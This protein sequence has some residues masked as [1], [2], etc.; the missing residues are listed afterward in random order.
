M[1]RVGEESVSHSSVEG[2]RLSTL[3]RLAW[4]MIVARATQA[5][6]GFCDA[7]MTAPLGK[8]PLAA[9]T[10]GA[11]DV[12]LLVILPM[13]TVF[14]VQS[15]AAQL[16]GGG[17]AGEARRYARYGLAISAV[18]G[19]LAVAS[20]PWIDAALELFPYEPDVR[21]AMGDY[22]RVRLWSVAAIVGV[23][24]LGNWYGGLGNTRM[25]LIA[26]T[27]TMIA[28]VALNYALIEPRFGLPGY[29]VVGAASASVAA[30]WIA[31]AVLFTLY[32]RGVGHDLPK[33]SFSFKWDEFRRV[34]RFGLPNGFNWFLEFGAFALF[35]NAVVPKLGTDVLAAFNV[36]IQIN[37]IS[38]MPAFGAAS[39]GAI[40]V[41]EAIG[42]KR[43]DDV[44][45][46]ARLTLATTGAWMLVV[47]ASYALF[48]QA[49][50]E[51]F[52]PENEDGSALV[53]AGTLMLLM[54]AIW[55]L[56]DATALTFSEALRAAGDT[57]WPMVA[58]LLLAWGV[59]VPSAALAVYRF[60]GG[61][62]TIMLCLTAYIG[63]LAAL[64]VLRFRSGRWRRI[65]LLR[66]SDA[67]ASVP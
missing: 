2:P 46:A 21:A 13:G 27:A 14:I 24:A 54:S 51:L 57:T 42:A 18:S 22:L 4:P 44:P 9:V 7:L 65:N 29:G 11:M 28:N 56:F 47:G 23:E 10:T 64:L 8:S 48:P 32:A 6:V 3:L 52:T 15:F 50:F 20:M 1:E 38:F 45:K 31:F 33:A 5:V 16:R 43:H 55:Q 39:A 62:A 35:I 36:V 25:A 30:S 53:A 61:A 66:P 58:R 19:L 40:L 67:P 59:F 60:D 17:R 49:Y 26:G 63:L 12:M 41:G 34:L 37:M